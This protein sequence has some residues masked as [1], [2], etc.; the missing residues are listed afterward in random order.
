MGC[1]LSPTPM[2]VPT[3]T[4]LAP[5]LPTPMVPW[6]LLTLLR[7]PPPRLSLPL[8]VESLLLVLPTPASGHMAALL[9]TPTVPWSQLNLLMWWLL[10]PLLSRHLLRLKRTI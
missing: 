10:G 3:P 9:P 4:Q 5:W 6:S 1:P 2:L 7:L 8:L